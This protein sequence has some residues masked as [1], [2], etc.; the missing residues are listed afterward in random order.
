MKQ[1]I[2]ISEIA[3]QKGLEMPV[4]IDRALLKE[5]EPSPFLASLGISLEKRVENLMSLLNASLAPK[6]ESGKNGNQSIPFMVLKGPLVAEDFIHIVATVGTDDSGKP[7]VRLTQ[8][9]GD[10]EEGETP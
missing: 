8:S 3:E 9:G 2:N 5:L 6:Q 1:K 10:A 7:C 4:S